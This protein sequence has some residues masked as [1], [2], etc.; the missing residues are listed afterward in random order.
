M[1][2]DIQKLF[3]DD[4]IQDGLRVK[5]CNGGGV[6]VAVRRMKFKSTVYILRTELNA[7]YRFTTM[8]AI[9]VTILIALFH[10]SA[11]YLTLVLK[12]IANI[13]LLFYKH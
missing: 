10:S 9:G 5:E 4:S 7:K 12:S 8:K 11:L 2:E 13:T 6:I 1:K 3:R